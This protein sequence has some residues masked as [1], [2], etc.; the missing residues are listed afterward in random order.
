VPEY[1]EEFDPLGL[2]MLL[3]RLA[4]GAWLGW[5]PPLTPAGEPGLFPGLFLDTEGL[6]FDTAGLF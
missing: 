3:V 5:L 2:P 4:T 1:A 6:V